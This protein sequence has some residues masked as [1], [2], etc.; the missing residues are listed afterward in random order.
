MLTSCR[1]GYSFLCDSAVMPVKYA[2]GDLLSGA[3]AGITPLA[4]D[5]MLKLF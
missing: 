4:L 2:A 5:G 1:G 3:L